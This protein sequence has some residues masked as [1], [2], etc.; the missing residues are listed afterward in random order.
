MP[1]FV[2]L[3]HAWPIIGHM[4]ISPIFIVVIDFLFIFNYLSYLKYMFKYLIL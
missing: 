4:V 3:T 1:T 2:R